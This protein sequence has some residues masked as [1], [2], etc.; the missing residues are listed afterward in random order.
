[1][2]CAH[3]IPELEAPRSIRIEGSASA[4]AVESSIS[5]N[6]PTEDPARIHQRAI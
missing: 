1:M 6:R 2:F 3:W 4:I 5:M